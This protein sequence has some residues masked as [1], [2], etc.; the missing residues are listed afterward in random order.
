ML[1]MMRMKTMYFGN[2]STNQCCFDIN[3]HVN[4]KGICYFRGKMFSLERVEE[5]NIKKKKR[6]KGRIIAF[7]LVVDDYLIHMNFEIKNI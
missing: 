4:F 3:S 2:S 7:H 5:L 6:F 1:Y